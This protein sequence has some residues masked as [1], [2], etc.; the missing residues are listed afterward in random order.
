MYDQYNWKD[1]HVLHIDMD[2]FYAS[3]EE[4][5]DPSLRFVPMAVCGDPERRHGIILA[6]N[7][8]AKGR[9][10]KTGMSLF[11]ARLACPNIAFVPA[12]MHRYVAYSKEAIKIY[13]S[14]SDKYESYGIDEGWLEVTG[15]THLFGTGYEV[16]KMIQ[17]DIKNKLGLSVSIGVS[18]NKSVAK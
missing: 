12:R 6:K 10:V 3:V 14:Y 5:Y 7:Q 1:R 2:A 9:G 4:L 8:L 18:F 13:C 11:D 15:C 16:A 17:S